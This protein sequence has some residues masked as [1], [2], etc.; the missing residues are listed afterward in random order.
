MI[1]LLNGN[2]FVPVRVSSFAMMLS[3]DSRLLVFDVVPSISSVNYKLRLWLVF[4]EGLSKVE[5]LYYLLNSGRVLLVF[6]VF[7]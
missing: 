4:Y 3:D 5:N 2:I 1:S 6:L 7:P